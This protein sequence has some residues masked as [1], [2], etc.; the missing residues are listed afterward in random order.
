[1]GSKV[2]LAVWL[3]ELEKQK[4]S[5]GNDGGLFYHRSADRGSHKAGI[6]KI[7]DRETIRSY[8]AMTYEGI[9][10]YI[11]AGLAKDS[12]E[13]KW[14]RICSPWNCDVLM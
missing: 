2:H 11:Y 9:K 7:A 4:L 13:V 6:V 10:T 12:P 5:V 1:M 8:G 14:I 3:A